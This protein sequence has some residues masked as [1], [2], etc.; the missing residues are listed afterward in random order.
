MSL[1]CTSTFSFASSWE[2]VKKSSTFPCT[3]GYFRSAGHSR[4]FSRPQFQEKYKR[5]PSTTPRPPREQSPLRTYETETQPSRACFFSFHLIIQ[6]PELRRTLGTPP[7]PPGSD[8]V[9]ACPS[10]RNSSTFHHLNLF[11][12]RNATTVFLH[13]SCVVA[14]DVPRPSK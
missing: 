13:S 10:P 3:P 14:V 2:V 6:H 1:F 11:L 5:G 8:Q 7:R 9:P 12:V 4:S